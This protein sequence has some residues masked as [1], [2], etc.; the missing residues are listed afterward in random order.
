[1]LFSLTRGLSLPLPDMLP[2]A[3]KLPKPQIDAFP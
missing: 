1:M 2:S 3:K